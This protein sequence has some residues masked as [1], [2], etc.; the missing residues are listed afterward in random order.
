MAGVVRKLHVLDICSV[1]VLHAS[2]PLNK[3]ANV[4]CFKC[5]E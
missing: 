3:T 5:L 1:D 4:S 2:F